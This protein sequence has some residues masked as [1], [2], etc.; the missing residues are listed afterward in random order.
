[1]YDFR[2]PLHI[3][4]MKNTHFHH[5]NKNKINQVNFYIIPCL[6]FKVFLALL[7]SKKVVQ[8]CNTLHI[9]YQN[10][11]CIASNLIFISI[12]FQSTSKRFSTFNNSKRLLKYIWRR[13]S[14]IHTE[15]V[16]KEWGG[17]GGSYYNIMLVIKNQI[18]THLLNATRYYMST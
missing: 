9:Q 2:H 10:T 18:H 16:C 7:F 15:S 13:E 12:L 4:K 5:K 8:F 14:C 1:M 11:K 17:G 6:S 3:H